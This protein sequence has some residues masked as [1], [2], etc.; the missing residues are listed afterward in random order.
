M[1][2]VGI[3]TIGI[4]VDSVERIFKQLLIS[5]IAEAKSCAFERFKI[6]LSYCGLLIYM[7]DPF[8]LNVLKIS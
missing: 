4:T 7:P 3:E 5:V 2:A 1:K 8:S 6:A